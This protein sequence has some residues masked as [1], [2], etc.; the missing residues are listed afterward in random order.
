VSYKFAVMSKVHD[1][2]HFC[3]ACEVMRNYFK[4]HGH[5][6]SIIR[7]DAG[8]IENSESVSQ[9][10]AEK[11]SIRIESASPECQYQN[12]CERGIQTLAKGVGAMFC[13]Q[14][15]L[16]NKTV[17]AWIDASNVCPNET[18][19][20]YSPEYFLTGIHPNLSRFRF[21][22]GQPVVSVILKQQQKR[23]TCS[24]HGEYGYA[25][26]SANKW[27]GSTLIYVPSKNK[28][29]I[30]IRRDVREVKFLTNT[31]SRSSTD[32]N[33][34]QHI[35]NS[36][37]SLSFPTIPL[38]SLPVFE[39][40]SSILPVEN[41]ETNE[42]EKIRVHDM[43]TSDSDNWQS[44]DD[45]TSKGCDIQNEEDDENPIAKRLRNNHSDDHLIF[46]L[47]V[48]VTSDEETLS[49]MP[50]LSQAKNSTEWNHLWKPR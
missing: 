27:N 32:F 9:Q 3:L 49:D 28:N 39:L 15:F 38:S 13:R 26:G 24:P 42:E 2:N 34:F 46:S 10:L 19:G 23:F 35:I 50:T 18:S 44:D 17:L 1:S 25:I 37:G 7:C 30:Y 8:T 11:F 31:Q 14:T 21:Y 33:V 41:K 5:T 45:N 22:Y 4:K 6:V 40:N 36:D 47:S 12:P 16:G 29:M 43:M 20:E 48:P